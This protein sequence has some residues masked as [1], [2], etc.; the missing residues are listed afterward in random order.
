MQWLKTLEIKGQL[1]LR[2]T[3]LK[4]ELLANIHRLK[5]YLSDFEVN[6]TIIGLF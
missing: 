6:M 2:L 5:T 1:S 4:L 3:S